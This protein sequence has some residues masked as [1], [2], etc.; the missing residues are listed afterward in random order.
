[1]SSFKLRIAVFNRDERLDRN[2]KPLKKQRL[3]DGT[4]VYCGL[5]EVHQGTWLAISPAGILQRFEAFG[6]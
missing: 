2:T 6:N 1:M 4:E 5:D 3:S